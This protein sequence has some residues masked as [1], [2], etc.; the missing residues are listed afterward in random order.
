MR[1]RHENDKYVFFIY[2]IYMWSIVLTFIKS[3]SIRVTYS[4]LR[5]EHILSTRE[6]GIVLVSLTNYIL[7]ISSQS[8][9]IKPVKRKSFLREKET[10]EALQRATCLKRDFMSIKLNSRRRSTQPP[11]KLPVS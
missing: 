4:E 10:E 9:M 2:I 6:L 8:K 7:I 11:P 5:T 1:S 3:V